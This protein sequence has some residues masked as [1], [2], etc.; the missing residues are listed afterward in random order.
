MLDKQHWVYTLNNALLLASWTFLRL[1][2]SPYFMVAHLWETCRI[3][4]DLGFFALLGLST[5]ALMIAMSA[6]W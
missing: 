6:A 4:S 5:Y 1:I 3:Q 2:Y